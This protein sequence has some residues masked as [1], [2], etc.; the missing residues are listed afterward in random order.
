VI[1][2]FGMLD[3]EVKGL[4]FVNVLGAVAQLRG[5]Q[6]R[7]QVIEAMPGEGSAALRLG[8]V[9]ASGWYPVRWY[10]E[11]FAA[12]VAVSNDASLP[13]E[14]GKASVRRDVKGVHRLLFKVMSIETLQ[15][16]GARFFKAFFRP[17]DV[18]VERV[19][20]CIARVRYQRCFGFD[21]NVWQ[22]QIG[23]VEELLS[24]SRVALPRVRVLSGGGEH[25]D[26]MDLE[27]RWQ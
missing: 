27:T 20:R 15:K 3:V 8:S 2:V 10:R 9:I 23:G 4:A 7:S 25:D 21:K 6:F 11:L 16:Q 17:T 18:S 12:S 22:E 13:R 19:D 26:R 5:D 14:L 1:R 24:Q